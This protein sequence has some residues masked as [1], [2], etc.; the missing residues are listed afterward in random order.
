MNWIVFGLLCGMAVLLNV[1]IRKAKKCESELAAGIVRLLRVGF[2][3][4]VAQALFVVSTKEVLAYLSL[5]CYY[6]CIDWLVI[7]LLLY[8]EDYTGAFHSR[9]SIRIFFE[10]LAGLDSVML[11]VNAC[12]KNVFTLSR[13]V[14]RGDFEVWSVS[15][16]TYPFAFH[17]VLAGIM[18]MFSAQ[19]LAVQMARV[20]AFYRG[21]FRNILV[22]LV[23]V[24][25]LNLV[26]TIFSLP[27]DV[28]V[29]IYA[30]FGVRISYYS[31]F[32]K[33]VDLINRTLARVVA[34]V[35]DAVFC[36]DLWGDCVYTNRAVEHYFP[37]ERKEKAI[38]EIFA[39]RVQE[40]REKEGAPEEWEYRVRLDGTERHFQM[41]YHRLEN[42]KNQYLGCFFTMHDRTEEIRRFNEEHYRITH[43]ELTGLY[44]REYFFEQVE[45]RLRE[46]PDEQYYLVCSNIKGFKLYNDLFGTGCGDEMLKMEAELLRAGA[47]EKTLYGRI[48]GDEFAILLPKTMYKAE[49]FLAGLQKMRERFDSSQYKVHIYLGVYEIRDIHESISV[50]CD[51]AKLAI[52]SSKGDYNALVTFFTDELLDKSLHERQIVGEFDRALENREFCIY[53]QPQFS[54]DGGMLGAEA[55]VRWKHPARGLV[56]PGDFVEVF[57]KTGLIYRLDRYV[58]E[59]AAAKLREWKD[60]GREDWYISVNIS[61][62]DFYYMDIYRE[63]TGLV[64][65]Y[66]IS[67][68]KL[69]LEITETVMMTEMKNRM[70]LLEQ[71]RGYGFEVEID[72]F[73]SGYSS[74][75]MLKDIDVDSIKID[76]GF[77][78]ETERG[79]RSVAILRYIIALIRQLKMQVITEGVETKEQVDSLTEMGCDVFQGYYF[80]KP[81]P[82]E[83]FE[84]K[85]C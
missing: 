24:V 34:G 49:P 70:G 63:V 68:K 41:G 3:A 84:E 17:M 71:L 52:E 80:A 5:G 83:Q 60:N 13:V 44:N 61:P 74:L 26:C 40:N 78:R 23:L 19:A 85:Y 22:C 51:K 27:Y 32:Y 46:N 53:L 20:P 39:P 35:D 47:R 56:F 58:W 7:V 30:V 12:S 11:L 48:A 76:M 18:V 33:P 67:P 57:E 75:N 15:N 50:M 79:E 54:T 81:M 8:V 69:K 42:E 9:K 6:A 64:E 31:L 14:A 21:R 55:L 59:L 77:L 10:A 29:F 25:V 73:G 43:D 4:L 38:E 45:K 2:C 65:R 72:D 28:S 62:K 16:R 66:G 36:F 37:G 1:W 82:V